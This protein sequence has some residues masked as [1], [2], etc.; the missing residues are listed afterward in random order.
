VLCGL[1]KNG[2]FAR[3]WKEGPL[4]AEEVALLADLL[5]QESVKLRTLE[6]VDAMTDLALKMLLQA[7]PSGA[8]GE[9]LFE[10][11]NFLLRRQA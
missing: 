7:D 4:R 8:A 2:A 5:A 1:E 9:A 3:R 11:V 10:L 6:T